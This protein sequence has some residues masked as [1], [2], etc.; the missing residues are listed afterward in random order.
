MFEGFARVREGFGKYSLSQFFES[1][2]N[3]FLR[4]LN[5]PRL[6]D[7]DVAGPERLRPLGAG[8]VMN[9][10]QTHQ[11]T[12]NSGELPPGDARMAKGSCFGRKN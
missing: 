12:Q 11:A 8:Y 9:R 5:I 2:R 4:K 6:I 7:H 3:Q 10:V 1:G